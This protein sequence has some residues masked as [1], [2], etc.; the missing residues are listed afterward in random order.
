[1]ILQIS[2]N[3]SK[4]LM[5]FFR[6]G[7]VFIISL[8]IIG[9]AALSPLLITGMGDFMESMSDIYDS[10]GVDITGMTGML[11][12]ASS[13]GVS[14][15]A[16]NIAQVGLIVFLLLI[17]RAAGGEQKR[18][19]II[20]PRSSGLQSVGYL[21]P[22]YIIY[23]ITA[24]IL[25]FIAMFASWGVSAYAFEVNDVSFNQV[26]LSGILMGMF[27]MLYVSFHITL[28]TAT[29]KPGM[30]AAICIAASILLPGIFGVAGS[31]YMFNP[32]ALSGLAGTVVLQPDLTS[33]E[34]VDIAITI[35]FAF[36]LLV[37]SYLIAL[38]AQNAT[39]IDNTGN[40]ME[41]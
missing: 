23:P 6:T 25:S 1:M 36:A 9:L 34:T 41:I 8:V 13:L 39:K 17:N 33:K 28:G 29:G 30:S 7:R 31:D 15:S 26:L 32:F 4:E 5:S 19:D 10:M 14:T 12:S 38:F 24:F 16:S 2:A 3:F 40:E 11:S 22:K 21:L 20:I 18:R 27:M 35:A 37:L